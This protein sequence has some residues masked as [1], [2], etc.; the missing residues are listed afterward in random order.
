MT[1]LDLRKKGGEKGTH[2]RRHR[3]A[4]LRPPPS[5]PTFTRARSIRLIPTP[6]SSS[7]S[8]EFDSED[9]AEERKL[10]S[11]EEPA[12]RFERRDGRREDILRGRWER[13]R[14]GK[15]VGGKEMGGREL[16]GV[17]SEWVE[18]RRKI[19]RRKQREG[20]CAGRVTAVVLGSGRGKESHE[21]ERTLPVRP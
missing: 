1:R 11:L 12:L 4:L 18:G 8:D 19:K 17:V 5:L 21:S 15:R 20:R 14:T 3:P 6:L 16:H 2:H 10:A 7:S 9:E 13:E